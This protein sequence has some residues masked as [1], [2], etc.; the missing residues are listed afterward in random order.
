MTGHASSFTFKLHLDAVT[1]KDKSL[2]PK[3]S[4]ELDPFR[5]RMVFSWLDILKV[6]FLFLTSCFS[7]LKIT[8]AH[9]FR[10]L[11]L[12][13]GLGCSLDQFL[14]WLHLYSAT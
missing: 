12:P 10:D 3:S 5:H 4:D 7:S 8:S 6:A 2:G 13:F 1:G 14:S 9:N 11:T